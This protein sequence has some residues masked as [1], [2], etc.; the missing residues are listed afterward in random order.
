MIVPHPWLLAFSVAAL[1]LVLGTTSELV[2][3]RLLISEP[4]A[5]ATFGVAIGPLGLDLL[6]LH[7]AHDPAAGVFLEEAARVTLAIAVRA[8]AIR[9][10]RGWLRTDRQARR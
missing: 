7:P 9:L 4:P 10:P 8:A 2:N 5:C 3:S 6:G 1:L